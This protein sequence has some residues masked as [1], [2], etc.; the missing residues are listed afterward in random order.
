MI[1]WQ[2][3]TTSR[4]A[5]TLSGEFKVT[6]P[7]NLQI[8]NQAVASIKNLTTTLAYP[9]IQTYSWTFAPYPIGFDL[10]VAFFPLMHKSP[11]YD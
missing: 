1:C 3:E 6:T 4:K 7:K 8:N 11:I 9:E 5:K 2:M 10:V